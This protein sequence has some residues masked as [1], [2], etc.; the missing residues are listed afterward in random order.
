MRIATTRFGE[1]EVEPRDVLTFPAGIAAFEDCRA[2]VLLGDAD[3][4]RIGWLQS[5]TAAEVALPVVSPR[6]W[7][8]DYRVRVG[9]G[10]LAALRLRPEHRTYVLSVIS[11][12]DAGLTLN[13]KAPL[14]VNLDRRLGRQVIVHD[15]QS[16]AW[17]ITDE[18][19]WRKSA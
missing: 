2:W 14:I 8:E 7:I 12:S 10:Q 3:N 15:D 18:T 13:L 5:L 6:A 19:P 16:L 1:I 17:P 11:R 9:D 4:E